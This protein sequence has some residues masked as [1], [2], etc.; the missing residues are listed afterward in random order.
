[1]N[2]L[3]RV[4]GIAGVETTI[5]LLNEVAGGYDARVSSSS[6]TGYR[7]SYEFIGDELLES[8]LKTGYLE[9]VPIAACE[10]TVLTA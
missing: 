7:E 6:A 3:Y 5:E 2:R 9:H 4:R 8:C 10:H 1:M